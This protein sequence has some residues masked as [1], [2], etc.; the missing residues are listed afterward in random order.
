MRTFTRKISHEEAHRMLMLLSLVTKVSE[1]SK[2]LLAKVQKKLT[3]AFADEMQGLEDRRE[4][5][6]A[7]GIK[8]VLWEPQDKRKK[9]VELK[10]TEL[11]AI[12][13]TL[14][15]IL[16]MDTS[17]LGDAAQVMNLADGDC[18][19]LERWMY[20]NAKVDDI[21]LV[22]VPE[23]DYLAPEDVEDNTEPI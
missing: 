2:V 10:H 8:H 17:G 15:E 4:A 20:R 23:D 5:A 12:A 6:N 18:L 14:L 13:N 16:K 1:A 7:E 22:D 19:M 9:D 11:S 3:T 21:E